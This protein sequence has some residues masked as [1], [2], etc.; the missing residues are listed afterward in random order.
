[1]ERQGQQFMAC[2][3]QAGVEFGREVQA[4][5]GRC[6][7]AALGRVGVSRLVTGGILGCTVLAADV[8]R[9]RNVPVRAR[10]VDD[11]HPFRQLERHQRLPVTIPLDNCPPR[12]TRQQEARTRLQAAAGLDQAPPAR[13]IRPRMQQEALNSSPAL[14][15]ARQARLQ[16]RHRVAHKARPAGRKVGKSAKCACST[17]P[18]LR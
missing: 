17:L 2:G 7:R 18:V 16:H 15:A 11:G 12:L 4:C 10:K 3:Q 13:G 8:G 6:D 14:P 5:R 9:Q 1:V